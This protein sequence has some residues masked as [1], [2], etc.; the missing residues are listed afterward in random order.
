M[1]I[2]MLSSMPAAVFSCVHDF[3][4]LQACVHAR[5]LGFCAL[6]RSDFLWYILLFCVAH[7]TGGEI[8]SAASTTCLGRLLCTGIGRCRGLT[9]LILFFTENG[10]FIAIVVVVGIVAVV[11]VMVMI[12][13]SVICCTCV[14]RRMKKNSYGEYIIEC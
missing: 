12:I 11:M 5:L 3:F 1:Y 9:K 6:F 13:G 7:L 10:K 14:Y 2:P 4:A 8:A